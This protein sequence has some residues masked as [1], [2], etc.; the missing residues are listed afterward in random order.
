MTAT[1][2]NLIGFPGLI[3]TIPVI[4]AVGGEEKSPAGLV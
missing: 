2:Q 4:I 1:V 3:L